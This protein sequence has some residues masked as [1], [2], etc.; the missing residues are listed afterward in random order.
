MRVHLDGLS[1]TDYPDMV[2]V[3]DRLEDPTPESLAIRT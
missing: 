1:T 2:H 3:D